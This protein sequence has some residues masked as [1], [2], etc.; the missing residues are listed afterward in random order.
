M[1]ITLKIKRFAPEKDDAPY[2][3]RFEVDA[4]PADRLLDV[5]MNIKQTRDGGLSFRKSCAHGV[6]GSDAMRINGR[7]RLACKTLV[8]DVA[9]KEGTEISIEPLRYFPVERDLIVDQTSF[10]HRYKAVKPYLINDEP[11]EGKE[12]RQSPDEHEQIKDPINCILCAACM[13]ACPI[14]RKNPDFLGP[15]IIVQ[16]SRFNRDSRDRGIEERLSILNDPNGVWP[17][18]NHFECT[19]CCPRDI[20]VTKLI[21]QSKKQIKAYTGE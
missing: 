13:S 9:D 8:K 20:K 4:E 7:E 10:F 3:E 11:V 12:R 2:D 18:E 15:A 1:K 6:C 21:N 17:C 19:K 14:P 16:A 5:L